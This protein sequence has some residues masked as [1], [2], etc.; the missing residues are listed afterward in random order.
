M[1]GGDAL[2]LRDGGDSGQGIARLFLVRLGEQLA[3][4]A[5]D[6][7]LAADRMGIRH[8][9]HCKLAIRFSHLKQARKA[10]TVERLSPTPRIRNLP[11]VS[12][13]GTWP[14]WAIRVELGCFIYTGAR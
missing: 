5:K 1:L 10:V 7:A 11:Y 4:I 6:K 8:G 3:Q 9:A 14:G 12:P 13:S 2:A